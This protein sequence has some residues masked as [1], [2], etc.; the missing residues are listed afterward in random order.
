MIELAQEL[1]EAPHSSGPVPDRLEASAEASLAL[2]E[3]ASND[4]AGQLTVDSLASELSRIAQQFVHAPPR[5]L[6]A[7]LDALRDTIR[8]ALHTGPPP[9]RARELLVLAGVTIE[10]LAQITSNLGNPVAA[11]QH[12]RAAESL[13]ARAGHNGLRAWTIGTQALITEWNTNPGSA[14]EIARRA[15]Q[16]SPTGEHKIRLAALEARCAARLGRRDEAANATTEAL[17][18]AETASDSVDDVGAFGGSLRFPTTKLAYY[19]GTT[20]RLLG[21]ADNAEWWSQKAVDGYTR[22]REQDRSYGDEA[23]ARA[24][25][26]IVRITGRAIDGAREILAPVF[27]LS[28]AQHIHPVAEGLRAVDNSLRATRDANAPIARTLSQEID[29]FTSTQFPPRR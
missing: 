29:V 6:V 11:M 19:L 12:A 25:I 22:G 10:L 13:A 20:Y 26:A 17:A 23:L 4:H 1:G 15:S 16:C 21:E 8:R 5:P 3:W 9:S 27:A 14:I 24:D 7:E 18:T 28:P 2:A